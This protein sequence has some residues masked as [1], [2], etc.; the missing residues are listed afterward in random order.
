MAALDADVA[1]V[2]GGPGG[3]A[4]GVAL[5]I[6]DPGLRIK[7]RRAAPPSPGLAPQAATV[8]KVA[9]GGGRGGAAVHGACVRE[10][11]G[12]AEAAGREPMSLLCVTGSRR[13]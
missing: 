5:G 13:Q 10:G 3:L 7:V 1:I 12:L 6:A 2:G 11:G 4:A 9:R 8:C